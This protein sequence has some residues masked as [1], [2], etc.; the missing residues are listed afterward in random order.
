MVVLW[1]VLLAPGAHGQRVGVVLSGGGAKGMAHI[2]VLMALEEH[3]I[4]IDYITGTSAGALVGAFY[5]AGYTPWEID[6]LAR[7]ESQRWLAPGSV[8]SDGYFHP[9]RQDA[10][11]LS[12]PLFIDPQRGTL[13]EY[14]Y[15]DYGINFG[16]TRYLAHAT[17]VAEHNF[18]SLMVPFRCRAADISQRSA[19]TLKEGSLAF[20]VRASIAVPLVFLPAQNARYSELFDG[21]LYD[22]FPVEVMQEAWAPDFIIGVDVG[23][24][25]DPN[26]PRTDGDLLRQILYK[27][28]DSETYQR[29]PDSSFFIQPYMEGIGSTDFSEEN[30]VAAI[31]RGYEAASAC[32]VD[33]KRLLKRRLTTAQL[34]EKRARYRSQAPEVALGRV[35]ISGLDSNATRF[36]RRLFSLQNG[37]LTN[38]ARLQQA[39]YRMQADGQFTSVLPELLYD[40]DSQRYNLSLFVR[41]APQVFIRFGGAF[42]SPTQHHLQLGIGYRRTGLRAYSVGLNLFSGS[43]TRG[44]E[45]DGSILFPGKPSFSLQ[46]HAALQA[47]DLR[48]GYD[49]LFPP[50]R[51]A[52]VRHE[53]LE[54]GLGFA[55]KLNPGGQLRVG[56]Y[57]QDLRDRYPF[58]ASTTT[59]ADSLDL[60][61]LEGGSLFLQ[62]TKSSLDRKQYPTRGRRLYLSGRWNTGFERFTPYNLEDPTSQTYHSW[63]QASL[64]YDDYLV[65]W[66]RLHIGLGVDAAYSTLVDFSNERATL[67]SSPRFTPF[68]DSPT[69]FQD[70]LYKKFFIAPGT[71]WA[72]DLSDKLQARA[73]LHWMQRFDALLIGPGGGRRFQLNLENKQVVGMLGLNLQTLVGPLG[74]YA[75]YYEHP[76]KPWRITLHLGYLL[77]RDHPWR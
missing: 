25:F 36:A 32:I 45:L 3:G 56:Y 47:W 69:L 34:A 29:L 4:P 21:G 39:Y 68:P 58:T 73:E 7:I 57:Y 77:F 27:A 71:M 53:H 28:M 15:S 60:T 2:G 64:S 12:L 35:S 23:S 55:V 40:A 74:L 38:W 49:G 46:G 20:A 59:D 11:F 43:Y 18:D 5:A 61:Q 30:V 70:G 17:A 72:F 33:L 24:V 66:G 26:A 16:L 19:V 76:S 50:D 22:N 41:K 62:L 44:V 1:L 14:V 37:E 6:S 51:P 10:T 75:S 63:F 8:L 65:H 13:P 67:L 31:Q 42:F 52:N 9:E 54:A 48:R